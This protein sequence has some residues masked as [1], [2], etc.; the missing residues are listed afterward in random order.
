TGRTG[1]TAWPGL[2]DGENLDLAGADARGVA[3]SLAEQ[4]PRERRHIGERAL[5]R[6]RL[7]LA[8]DAVGLLAAVLADE[9]DAHPEPHLAGVLG[10]RNELGRRAPRRPVA[11]VACGGV[12]RRAVPRRLRVRIG[13]RQTRDLAL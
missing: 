1:G 5:G 9:G 4:R 11:Q 6:I 13:T 12:E 7:V 10:G 8:D 3:D 2:R